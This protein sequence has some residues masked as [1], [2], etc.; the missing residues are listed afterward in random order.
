MWAVEHSVDTRASRAAVWAAWADVA[1][2]PVWDRGLDA[3]SLDG[4]FAGGC[5]GRL[6]PGGLRPM[7][8]T[9]AGVE[10]LRGFEVV[11]RLPLARLHVEHALTDGPGGRTRVTHRLTL[12]GPLAPWWARAA[13]A[14][15]AHELPGSVRRLARLAAADA[16]GMLPARAVPATRWAA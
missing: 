6:Q 13:G 4:A 9:L 2:W 16:S 11:A 14:R 8:F 3:A 5:G 15:I 1:A 10:P 12:R 7:D